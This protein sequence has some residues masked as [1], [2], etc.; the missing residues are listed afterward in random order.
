MIDV[1]E[2]MDNYYN[3]QKIHEAV[4]F[5]PVPAEVRVQ[6][7]RPGELLSI[8]EKFPVAYQPIGTLE[9]H[10]RQ[11]PL[12]C[13]TI[14]AEALCIEAAK[15]TGGAV[16]PSI[17]FGTDTTWDAGYGLGEGMDAAAGFNL[18]GSFYKLPTELLKNFYKAICENYLARG[19]K[20][21]IIVSG[22]NAQSQQ[23]LFD[24]L[25]FEMKTP[26]GTQPVCFTMEYTVIE[27]GDPLRH[28]DHAGFYETSMMMLLTDDRVNIKANDGCENPNLA[29]SD[30]R[31]IS[32]SSASEGEKYLNAQIE[33]LVKFAQKKFEELK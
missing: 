14:K 23:H 8:Q 32:E 29:M 19:F 6:Y 31:P 20:L 10:G 4:P 28:S 2:K 11:N 5:E 26:Q 7:L 1:G 22:H 24:E 15:K 9:W 25:C 17:Y 21:V 33:G 13:D 3:I 30:N 12:G 16:M 27:K 18:P